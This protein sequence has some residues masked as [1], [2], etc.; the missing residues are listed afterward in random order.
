[1]CPH[2]LGIMS[3]GIALVL[4][5][6]IAGGAD[7]TSANF[8]AL[9]RKW[10][11]APAGHVPGKDNGAGK[12]IHN[13]GKD[14]GECHQPNGTANNRVFT[15]AGT[16][17]EDRAARKPLVG[18]EVILQDVAGNV[19]SMT[20]NSVGNFWTTTPLASN[21]AAVASYGGK[22][23]PL[24]T[25]ATP[26]NPSDSRTWQYKAWVRNQGQVIPM[27]TIAPVGAAA[28]A[29]SRMSCNMHHSP[30][31]RRGGLWV[32]RHNSLPSYPE[33]DVSFQR[34]VRPI[35]Q[36]KCVP[37]HIPGATSSRLV[38]KTDLGSPA[39]F[40]DFSNGLDLTSYG[41]SN[42]D[43]WIK[44]GAGSLTRGYESKAE[45]APIL[46]KTNMRSPA[47]HAGGSFWT[48]N[49]ADYRVLRQW[50]VEGAKDN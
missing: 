23:Q 15:M 50:V 32:S 22:T 40:I 39:T 36:S 2:S 48:E 5:Y 47:P 7:F 13:P 6:G 16:L 35:L 17:Y 20:S 38:T 45:A 43:G 49:D 1:M 25:N 3:C 11:P 44:R 8:T 4:Y 27:V 9:G 29:A 21:P 46:S 31:G 10:Q 26:A 18:G 41:G 30:E 33:T 19:I 14:C 24:Y 28:D 37:C 34:H 12:G 42:V